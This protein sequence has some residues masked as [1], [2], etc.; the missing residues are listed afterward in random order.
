VVWYFQ[1]LC[2]L[3]GTHEKKPVA[4]FASAACRS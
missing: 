1:R 4:G 2:R 3:S